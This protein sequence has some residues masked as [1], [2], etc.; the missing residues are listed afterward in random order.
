M[1]GT[2]EQLKKAESGE[3]EAQAIAHDVRHALELAEANLKEQAASSKTVIGSL[4][5]EIKKL[6]T[7]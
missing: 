2:R 7:R 3:L 4:Q 6:K 1:K 5:L